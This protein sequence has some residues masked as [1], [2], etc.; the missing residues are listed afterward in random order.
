MRLPKAVVEALDLREGD[1]IQITVA[2]SR[3]FEVGI[4]KTRGEA[5]ARIRRL[6]R[7][8]PAG[9]KFDRDEANTRS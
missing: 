5:L 6:R 1:D 4:D 9:W 2:G 3:S 7:P 8:L